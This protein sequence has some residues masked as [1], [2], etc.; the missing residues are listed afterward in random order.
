MDH[1]T[2]CNIFPLVKDFLSLSEM[3]WVWRRTI[4]YLLP[5]LLLHT[6]SADTNWFS[7]F[8]F[9]FLLNIIFSSV[10]TTCLTIN[11]WTVCK[12]YFWR[13]WEQRKQIQNQNNFSKGKSQYQSIKNKLWKKF[14][15]NHR[16][17]LEE[18]NLRKKIKKK[19][20]RK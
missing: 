10:V 8:L 4:N 11:H 13:N 16:E 17:N 14:R 18:K 19:K 5:L 2:N 1:W 7:T 3:N 20:M 15:K 12:L 6:F 9:A